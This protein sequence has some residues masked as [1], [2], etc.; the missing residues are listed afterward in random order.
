MFLPRRISSAVR[1]LYQRGMTPLRNLRG[2]VGRLRTNNP[3][4]RVGQSL[5]GVR[6]RFG[7]Y[8]RL[9]Q[10]YL[11]NT[12]NFSGGRNGDNEA[13]KTYEDVSGGFELGSNPQK[14]K[15]RF[16]SKK[17]VKREVN[18]AA[19]LQIHLMDNTTG[20]H[21]VIHIGRGANQEEAHY[22]L[23]G[24]VLYFSL[25]EIPGVLADANVIVRSSSEGI[26]V[27]G[28]AIE[29]AALLPG[30]SELV[31]GKRRY[32]VDIQPEYFSNREPAYVYAAWGTDTG[33]VRRDNQDAI[34]IYEADDLKL[35]AIADGVGSGYRGDKMSEFA[36]KY[37]LAA[38]SMN[39]GRDVDQ[40][41]VLSDAMSNANVEIRNYVKRLEQR[42][43]TT[44]TAVLIE[45]WSATVLHI[46]DSRL[47]LQRDHSISQLTQDHSE[48]VPIDDPSTEDFIETG[49]VLSKAIGKSNQINPDIFVLPLQASDRLLLCT[50]G[51]TTPVD[52]DELAQI[53]DEQLLQQL[54]DFLL[55]LANERR[56]TDNSSVVV[57]DILNEPQKK[58]TQNKKRQD[59]VFV[60]SP[61]RPIRYQNLK[62]VSPQ[63]IRQQSETE[64]EERLSL[65]CG[66]F[67][68]V[69]LVT[70]LIMLLTWGMGFVPSSGQDSSGEVPTIEPTATPVIIQTQANI[71]STGFPATIT[72][73]VFVTAEEQSIAP[74]VTADRPS[75]EPTVTAAS[76]SNDPTR[77]S[78]VAIAVDILT[79][80]PQLSTG[81][82]ATLRPT[83]VPR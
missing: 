59:R 20:I 75:L 56:T 46:G 15:Q 1:S 58:F 34:G 83:N 23:N 3:V 43:G 53:L 76:F 37:L 54:P 24:A 39:Y 68:L 27:N 62:Q 17:R 80:T 73:E 77:E 60:A 11:G 55:N 74:T 64:E 82:T 42:A 69:L 44:F 32:F 36:V 79:P 47:Y 30:G 51:I 63:K 72:L 28:E 19:H 18:T 13:R 65:G 71:E 67:A 33:T 26:L 66:C 61:Q 12:F 21:G 29:D 8:L 52:D 57:I 50:D 5:S 48:V 38:L 31:V 10:R 49:I 14:A 9:P 40:L 41:S 78:T 45:D 81:A 16:R 6:Q 22:M 4:S 2:Q 35:Y 70:A 7:Y 25:A